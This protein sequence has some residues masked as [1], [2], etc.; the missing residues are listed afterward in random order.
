MGVSAVR[1]CEHL[2]ELLGKEFEEARITAMAAEVGMVNSNETSKKRKNENDPKSKTSKQKT[3]INFL[4]DPLACIN[5]IK[6]IFLTCSLICIA[7]VLLQDQEIHQIKSDSFDTTY[8]IKRVNIHY[9]CTCPDWRNYPAPI[10]Q[11]TCKHLCELLSEEYESA[12]TASLNTLTSKSKSAKS[13][14][15]GVLLSEKWEPSMD[16][17]GYWI[18]EKL[19]GVRA[20]WNGKTFLSREGEEFTAPDW[21]TDVLPKDILLDGELYA[22]RGK[23]QDVVTILRSGNSLDWKGRIQY[24][25]FDIV[26]RS[27]GVPFEERISQLQRLF[28]VKIDW[29]CLVD[30]EKCRSREHLQQRLNAVLKLGGE[31]VMLREPKSV[32]ASGRSRTLY[33]VKTF[34][35]AEAVVIGYEPGMRRHKGA[36]GAL[37]CKME[38]GK[39]FK[40]LTGLSETVRR[41]PPK[42]VP[43]T[44]GSCANLRVRL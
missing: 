22:G 3:L 21:F 12:R 14:F 38:N 43:L 36:L 34:L 13:G 1:T 35:D 7:N 24:H 31:G 11:R 19:D 29:I 16:P 44:S 20:L 15:Q 28:P 18:S 9:S 39:E 37:K 8:T 33:K 32:Y 23:I 26:D 41:N 30:H 42:I 40:I 5:G 17:T 2:K 6:R 10:S 25:I 27:A 4:D